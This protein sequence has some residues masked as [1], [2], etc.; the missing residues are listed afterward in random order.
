MSRI[1]E[2]RFALIA[3][4]ALAACAHA[5][6]TCDF[7]SFHIKPSWETVEVAQPFVVRELR[8]RFVLEHDESGAAWSVGETAYAFELHGADGFTM[9]VPVAPDGSF[10]VASL[11]PGRYCFRTGS[12]FFSGYSGTIVIDPH[13]P[14]DATIRLDVKLGA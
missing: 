12:S 2:A 6:A 9:N 11:R 14:A 10:A 8:G 4:V 13:A 7:G 3:V 1:H 5:P